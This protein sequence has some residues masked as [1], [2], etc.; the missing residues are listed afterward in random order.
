LENEIIFT[1]NFIA[2]ALNTNLAEMTWEIIQRRITGVYH[3]AGA[4]RIRRYDFAKLI[5]QAFNLDTNLIKPVTSAN[6]SWAANRPR[7]SSLKTA[8]AH[9]MLKSKPLKVGQSLERMKKETEASLS[10]RAQHHS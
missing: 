5:A 9:Q 6:F 7:D 8:K 10:Q 1:S 4:T 3:L 2:R